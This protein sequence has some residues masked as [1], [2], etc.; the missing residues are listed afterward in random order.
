MKLTERQTGLEE[1][2]SGIAGTRVQLTVRGPRSFT[3]SM[4][5]RNEVAATKL[6]QF[7]K[8]QK[9]TI[10]YDEECGTCVYLEVAI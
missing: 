3:F 5:S 8:G 4:D 2:A 6:I 9:C 1:I 7:F 10:D